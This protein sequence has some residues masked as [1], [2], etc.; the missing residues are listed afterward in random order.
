[1]GQR[2][3]ELDPDTVQMSL[4]VSSPIQ[5]HYSMLTCLQAFWSSLIVYYLSLGLT[6]TSILLQYQRV[7]TTKRFQSVCWTLMGLVV[8]YTIWT[9]FSSIFACVPVRAFWTREKASCINQFAMWL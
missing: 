7:F 1:M 3:E 2:L 6:K 5:D 4:Q 9:V 8:V